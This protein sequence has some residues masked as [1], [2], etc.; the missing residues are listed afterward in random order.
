MPVDLRLQVVHTFVLNSG[1]VIVATLNCGYRSPLSIHNGGRVPG[2]PTDGRRR[3]PYRQWRQT[4]KAFDRG[5]PIWPPRSK[6]KDD[7]MAPE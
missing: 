7:R 1:S 3:R 4:K 6:A 2:R 5:A